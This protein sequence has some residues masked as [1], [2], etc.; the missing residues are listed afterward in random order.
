MSWRRWSL[1]GLGCAF[2]VEV[3]AWEKGFIWDFVERLEWS[4]MTELG[5][6]RSRGLIP[7]RECNFEVI[8]RRVVHEF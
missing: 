2:V 8:F 3:K 7:C 4:K 1:S 5:F 6:R